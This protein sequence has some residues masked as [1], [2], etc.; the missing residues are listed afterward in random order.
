[1]NSPVLNQAD[2][3]DVCSVSDLVPYS[4]VA[5]LCGNQQV[6]L[7]YVPD[8]PALVYAI[9]NYD[10]NGRANVLSRGI[11][12]DRGGELV[13]A[14]PLYK[15]HFSLSTGICCE[16]PQVRVKTFPTRIKDDAVL[17]EF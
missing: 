5:V 13:V 2:G 17:I 15:Q 4:G 1:M 7:F 11:L 12:G 3:I 8:E 6:A 9:A 16:D 14:S 10:P